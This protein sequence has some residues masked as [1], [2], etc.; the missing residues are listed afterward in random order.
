MFTGKGHSP[1]RAFTTHK[2]TPREQK[3]DTHSMKTN[4]TRTTKQKS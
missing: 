4:L 2:R 1:E 3:F